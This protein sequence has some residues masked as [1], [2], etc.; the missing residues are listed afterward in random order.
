MGKSRARGFLIASGIQPAAG[1][2]GGSL[3]AALMVSHAYFDVPRP[4]PD[5]AHDRQKG[6]FLGPAYSDAEVKAFLSYHNYPCQEVTDEE[7]RLIAGCLADGKVVGYLVGRME[8]G[9]PALGA[10][11]ILGDARRADTHRA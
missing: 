6:S 3:G 11:S 10:R 4:R 2:A 1:D 5:G 9:P 7:R 8:F